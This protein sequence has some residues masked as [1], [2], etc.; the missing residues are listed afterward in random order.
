MVK[1]RLSGMGGQFWILAQGE[2]IF[3]V[4]V[5]TRSHDTMN[6]RLAQKRAAAAEKAPSLRAA[7]CLPI[8][9]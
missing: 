6:A 4:T 8:G 1:F 3:L 9:P 7:M 5:K 2:R